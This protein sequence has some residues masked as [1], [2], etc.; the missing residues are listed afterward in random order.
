MELSMCEKQ[1]VL[2]LL[3]LLHLHLLQGR[4]PPPTTVAPPPELVNAGGGQ[5]SSEKKLHSFRRLPGL[6][7]RLRRRR[8][9]VLVGS[10]YG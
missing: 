3:L 9:T 1:L 5:V 7:E 2:L 8:V 4:L 6:C 10:T